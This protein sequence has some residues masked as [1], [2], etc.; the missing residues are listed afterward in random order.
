MTPLPLPTDNFYKF[1]ALVGVVLILAAG[2]WVFDTDYTIATRLADL[3]VQNKKVKLEIK[4][5]QQSLNATREKIKTAR[6]STS[7]GAVPAPGTMN[8]IQ[9]D[10]KTSDDLSLRIRG[11]QADINGLEEQSRI[12]LKAFSIAAIAGPFMFFF[13]VLLSVYGFRKWYAIQQQ[14]DQLLSAEVAAL[15][16]PEP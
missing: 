10:L 8:E 5:L 9:N 15:R 2:Y 4:Y 1:C 11:K 14:M 6:E 12:A 13:G 16:K 7:H 3:G